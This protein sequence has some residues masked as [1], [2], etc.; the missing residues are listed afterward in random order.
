[1]IDGN[2]ISLPEPASV[3]ASLL[4]DTTGELFFY[5]GPIPSPTMIADGANKFLKSASASSDK[6][7]SMLSGSFG[8]SIKPK[9]EYAV[10]SSLYFKQERARRRKIQCKR[11]Y[12]R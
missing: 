12:D 10:L 7:K 3:S 9:F 5:S 6:D 2:E 8:Y 4:M 1:M 11:C